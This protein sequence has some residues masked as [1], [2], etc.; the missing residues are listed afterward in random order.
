MSL[1]SSPRQPHMTRG[2]IPDSTP[3]ALSVDWVK[4]LEFPL[5]AVPKGTHLT[6]VLSPLCVDQ[7]RL[8]S[9]SAAYGDLETVR[10]LLTERRVELPTEPTD[11]NPAVVAAHFGHT[12]VV[13][14]LLESLPGKS[15]GMSF[16]PTSQKSPLLGK[17]IGMGVGG[18][19]PQNACFFTL[20]PSRRTKDLGHQTDNPE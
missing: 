1:I 5:L 13:Q 3:P 17:K 6:E 14:E 16:L 9:I 12:D 8:L 11:D 10:Y 2:A 15:Q 18:S 7:G 20:S 4:H 19:F